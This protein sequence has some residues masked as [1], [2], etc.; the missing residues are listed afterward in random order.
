MLFIRVK[1]PVD[2]VRLVH[3]ICKDAASGAARKQCRFVKRLTPA[4]LTEKAH[5]RNFEDLAA[6][7]LKPVFHGEGVGSRKVCIL[8]W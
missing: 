3:A 2:P 8:G 7:V 6:R 1:P 5:E 4:T